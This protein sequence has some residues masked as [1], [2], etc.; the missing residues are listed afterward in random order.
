MDHGHAA[1]LHHRGRSCGPSG[2]KKELP[3]GAKVASITFNNDFGKSYSKGFKAAIKGTNI[4]L[5]AEE[6]HEATRRT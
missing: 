1:R 3:N 2:C 5:V 4:E 6:L